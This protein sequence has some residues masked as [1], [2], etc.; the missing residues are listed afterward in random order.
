MELAES[1]IRGVAADVA[2]SC[3]ADLAFMAEMSRG[4]GGGGKRGQQQQQ[5]GG[6]SPA[7]RCAA[8]AAPPAPFARMTYDEAV[9]TLQRAGPAA[10]FEA[11]VRWDAGLGSEHERFLAERVVGGPV[12][13]TDYPAVVKPFYALANG[14][15]SPF[16]PTVQAFDLLLP[17]IVRVNYGKGRG[18]CA[19]LVSDRFSASAPQ[20]EPL[21]PTRHTHPHPLPQGE[22][23]GGSAREHRFDVLA[24][25]MRSAGLLSPGLCR[26]VDAASGDEAP[27]ADL[28][29]APA[30]LDWYLDLRRYGSMPHA[31]W[32]LGVERLIMALTGVENIRD[33]LPVPRTPSSCRM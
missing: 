5:S 26:F 32:G 16:G 17:Q 15:A 20:R 19:R 8:L 14:V 11:P 9:A 2:A 6:P 24:A 23:V 29:A 21:S 7:E 1:C 31:G 22:V 25:R 12:F 30:S 28:A 3:E 13:V 27:P 18:G 33:V 4:S 10:A